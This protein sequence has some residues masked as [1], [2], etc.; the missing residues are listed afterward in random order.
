[1]VMLVI[2]IV[3]AAA[4][5]VSS[6]NSSSIKI[7]RD[8][9]TADA[10][11]KA[12]EALIGRALADINRPGSLPCPDTDDDGSAETLAGDECPSYTGRLPW[13]TLGLPDLRDGTGE[14]LWYALSQ[15]FHD[16]NSIHINS[17]TQGTLSIGGTNAASSV[18]AIVFSPGPAL[19]SASRS[20]SITATCA[21]LKNSPSVA[22]SLCATNYLEGSNAALNVSAVPATPNL[23]YQSANSSSTFNDQMILITHRELMPLVEKRIAREVKGCL[24]GY[25]LANANKYPW[26]APVSDT[27]NYTGIPNTL[28]G[29]LPKS[30]SSYGSN[31]QQLLNDIAALLSALDNYKANPGIC[32]LQISL[33]RE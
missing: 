26:A 11:A 23:N 10:L 6:L 7:A 1:M 16:D 30:M 9:T 21:S 3:G 28:F 5:L 19:N 12:K 15:K 18:I 17:E 20:P 8:K 25:A 22:Q 24:D 31:D 33:P 13:R 2:M 4:L 27:T 32:Q 14:R 29:R